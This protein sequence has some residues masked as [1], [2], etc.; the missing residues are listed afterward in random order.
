MWLNAIFMSTLLLLFL[1]EVLKW[2][3]RCS[4]Y[5]TNDHIVYVTCIYIMRCKAG[6]SRLGNHNQPDKHNCRWY[7]YCHWQPILLASIFL[8]IFKIFSQPMLDEHILALPGNFVSFNVFEKFWRQ[9][10]L[11]RIWARFSKLHICR[12]YGSW[13]YSQTIAIL[14]IQPYNMPG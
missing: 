8:D 14:A 4:V 7:T 3:F 11:L 5:M 9:N 6:W 2:V 1:K 10:L 12:G 13:L